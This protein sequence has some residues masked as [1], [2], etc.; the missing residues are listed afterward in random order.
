MRALA[1][2]GFSL[3][4][5]KHYTATLPLYLPRCLTFYSKLPRPRLAPRAIVTP[6]AKK[7]LHNRPKAIQTHQPHVCK[8]LETILK[9]KL[10]SHLSQISQ[11]KTRQRGFLPCQLT[12]TNLLSAEETVAP[13]LDKGDTV[14]IN[15]LDFAKAFDSV[16]HRLL[17]TKLKC[18]G[19]TPSVI[20]C[21]ES[22]LRQRSFHVSVNGSLSPRLQVESLKVQY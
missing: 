12:V 21:I 11:L 8:I 7:L 10:Q 22:Y 6:V 20:N 16:N 5:S 2:V 19:I 14:A 4:P 17:P 9:E 15:Y 1:L 3:R 13:W 18:Y